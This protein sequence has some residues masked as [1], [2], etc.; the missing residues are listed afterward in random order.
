M[1]NTHTHTYTHT[2]EHVHSPSLWFE[3]WVRCDLDLCMF[4]FVVWRCKFVVNQ[5]AREWLIELHCGCGRMQMFLWTASLWFNDEKQKAADFGSGEAAG[6]DYVNIRGRIRWGRFWFI[7]HFLFKC[8]LQKQVCKLFFI[9]VSFFFFKQSEKQVFEDVNVMKKKSP[10][11]LRCDALH[12]KG[13]LGCYVGVLSSANVLPDLMFYGM[14]QPV[15]AV[16]KGCGEYSATP[17]TWWKIKTG[18]I[19]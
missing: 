15:R 14:L 8:C 3:K 11:W 17:K 6:A 13:M 2:R 10:V 18:I 4:V 1:T 7:C 5:S 19:Y 12:P 9:F 16:Q